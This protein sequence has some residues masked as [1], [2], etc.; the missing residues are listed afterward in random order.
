MSDL[1][2]PRREV[3]KALGGVHL[4]T[5]KRWEREGKLPPPVRISR[6]TVGHLQSTLDGFIARIAASAGQA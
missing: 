4:E 6:K 5:V 3:A 1:F 2:L